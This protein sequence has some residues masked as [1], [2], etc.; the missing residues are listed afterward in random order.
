M[1]TGL[2]EEVGVIS[3]IK[4]G[5]VYDLVIKCPKISKMVVLGD[6]VAVNGVCLT[7]T[8]I[9]GEN[10]TF[11]AVRETVNTTCFLNLT[12]GSKVNLETSL[13]LSKPIGGHLVSGHVDGTARITNIALIDNSREITFFANKDVLR[14]VVDKGSICIDGISLTVARVTSESFTIAV[15]PHTLIETTLD[16]KKVGSVVNI[17]TDMIGKYIE[18]FVGG[19]NKKSLLELLTENG[20]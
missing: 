11:N 13:T 17:E 18:K 4:T 6:S 20:F 1:F 16:E 5:D 9:S 19:D 10:L 3:S 2:I 14:Y 12:H 8:D 15:I 7:V